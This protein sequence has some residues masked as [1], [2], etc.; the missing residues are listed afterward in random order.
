M[1]SV[2][3]YSYIRMHVRQQAGNSAQH[4]STVVLPINTVATAG[5]WILADERGDGQRAA[6]FFEVQCHSAGL[7]LSTGRQTIAAVETLHSCCCLAATRHG[8]LAAAR[9]AGGCMV[10]IF[11]DCAITKYLSRATTFTVNTSTHPVG[12]AITAN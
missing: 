2:T 11:S 9:P 10:Q 4:W 7:L 5:A 3:N 12:R 1:L 8:C 6:G